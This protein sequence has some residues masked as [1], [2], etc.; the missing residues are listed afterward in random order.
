MAFGDEAIPA[1]SGAGAIAGE[2]EVAGREVDGGFQIAT[3]RGHRDLRVANVASTL[4]STTGVCTP[5][6]AR[7]IRTTTAPTVPVSCTR[8]TN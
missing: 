1:L 7:G 5:T 2:R 4:R 3:S 8:H 6:R